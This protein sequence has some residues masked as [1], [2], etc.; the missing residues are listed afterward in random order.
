MNSEFTIKTIMAKHNSMFSTRWRVLEQFFLIN[1]NGCYWANDGHL[2]T[3]ADEFE[4]QIV[5][6]APNDIVLSCQ[7][8]LENLGDISVPHITD[9]YHLQIAFESKLDEFK[10]KNYEK[11]A[12]NFFYFFDSQ[13]P[14][15]KNLSRLRFNH[16]VESIPDNIRDDWKA[17]FLETCQAIKQGVKTAYCVGQDT[18]DSDSWTDDEAFEIYMDIMRYQHKFQN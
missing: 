8:T 7:R 15:F 1:G 14:D 6:L 12:S 10:K 9:A 5:E 18:L 13:I 4:N 11:I 2:V 17:I 16:V 3:S